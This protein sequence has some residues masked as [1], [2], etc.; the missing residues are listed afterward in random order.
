MALLPKFGLALLD[1][2]VAVI[3]VN[4]LSGTPFSL[5]TSSLSG[6]EATCVLSEE[7]LECL[8][9]FVPDSGKARSAACVEA[10]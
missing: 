5:S 1:D 7:V 10:S 2:L 8:S 3:G 6:G 9:L 4:C